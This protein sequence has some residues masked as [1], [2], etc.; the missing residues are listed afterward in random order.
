MFAARSPGKYLIM[1]SDN[2]NVV[3]WLSSRRPPN[4]FVGALVAA[5]ERL[6]YKFSPPQAAYFPR[7]CDIDPSFAPFC[8]LLLLTQMFAR[9]HLIHHNRP[10][11]PITFTPRTLCPY[12]MFLSGGGHLSVDLALIKTHSLRIGGHTYFTAMGMAPD[13]TDYLGR[14]KVNRCSLRYFRSSPSLTLTAI[15]RFFY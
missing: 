2:T 8:P 14:R 6:K 7:I 11:F 13:L 4:P 3:A 10:I 15:R 9:G 5:I 1:Y 12:I